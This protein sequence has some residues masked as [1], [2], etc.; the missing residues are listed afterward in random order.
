LI[1]CDALTEMQTNLAWLKM[2]QFDHDFSNILTSIASNDAGFKL[3]AHNISWL[4]VASN[5]ARYSESDFPE[6]L[7]PDLQKVDLAHQ[8][9]L[10]LLS[11]VSPALSQWKNREHL[12]I[13]DDSGQM[14][15]ANLIDIAVNFEQKRRFNN[16]VLRSSREHLL[17]QVIG[18]YMNHSGFEDYLLG[19][20]QGGTETPIFR[21]VANF[22]KFG[23]R[24][25][26]RAGV[27]QLS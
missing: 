20:L 14:V 22:S 11:K 19:A 13:S 1:A 27:A 2:H 12:V 3:G 18:R 24:N 23:S 9:A 4:S 26:Q 25:N 7:Q 8:T 17:T 10:D 6:S 16:R 21:Q 15:S 5:L